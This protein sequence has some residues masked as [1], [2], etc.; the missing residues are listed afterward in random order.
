MHFQA[1]NGEVN[2][3]GA[4]KQRYDR[5]D[6]RRMNAVSVLAQVREG[7]AQSRAQISEKLGLT[8]AT[9]SKIV[10]DLLNADLVKETE[11]LGGG[12]GRPGLQ[13]EFNADSGCVIALEMDLDRLTL[14]L[15][16]AG[17]ETLYSKEVPFP[18]G[19]PMEACLEL[20]EGLVKDAL[21]KG[22]GSH[23][24]CFGI[25]LAWAG[26]VNREEGELAY[27]P[28]FGWANVPVRA[29]WES[30]FKVPV[31]V[32]NEAHAG[33]MGAHHS[34]AGKGRRNL[35][36]LSQGVGL[37]A[38]VIVDGVLL[39]GKQGFAGQVGHTQFA[40]NG[41][42]CTCGKA[43]CWVTEIGAAAV[44]R[45]LEAAGKTFGADDKAGTGWIEQIVEEAG[46]TGSDARAVLKEVGFQTGLG[47]AKL[48]HTFN[49]STIIIGGRLAKL[50]KVVENSILDGL[51]EGVLPQMK[52]LLD[53]HI[54]DSGEDQ[55]NGCLDT[56]LESVMKDPPLGEL[57]SVNG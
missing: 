55:L 52:E 18:L 56:V 35:I 37:G 47:L 42:T 7:G 19:M 29:R 30:K 48:V 44:V 46:E 12:A 40:S 28:T 45:K 53:V 38:G 27:G 1:K 34:G 24:R 39:R 57:G 10:T 14:L 6:I 43:G 22:L 25:C 50:L 13:V 3:N 54:S 15:S 17:K 41:I 5:S 2:E 32:E 23:G 8:R 33:A 9:V 20:A 26:L 51:G 11:Y 49:P 36:F 21:S 4:T 31:H 16:N